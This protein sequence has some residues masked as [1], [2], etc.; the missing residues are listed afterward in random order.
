MKGEEKLWRILQDKLE[1][2]RA[3][4]RLVEAMRIGE[5]A[6]ELA[7]RIFPKNDPSLA[8][9][10][11]RLGQMHEQRGDVA[12]AK[13]HLVRAFRIVTGTEVGPFATATE[14]RLIAPPVM[15]RIS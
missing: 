5:T 2:L 10:H 7:Q 13:T 11:E 12:E 14:S 4:G 6:L 15:L 3:G 9:S 1:T 8:L